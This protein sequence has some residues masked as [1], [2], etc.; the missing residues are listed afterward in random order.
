MAFLSL[1]LLS[2]VGRAQSAPSGA[3]LPVP[4][5]PPTLA[6]QQPGAAS[7]DAAV[8]AAQAF[9]ANPAARAA[10]QR[11]LEAQA[12][13][14]ATAAQRRLQPTF[15]GTA[16][17]SYGQVAQ[18]TSLQSFYTLIGQLTI[19]FPNFGRLGALA[20]QGQAQLRAA[21]VGLD[22]VR[23]DLT[24]RA[25]DAYYGVL[26][27][28]GAEQIAHDNLEQAQRQVADTQKRVDAGDIAPA[29]VLK[30]QVPEAQARA[31]LIRAQ[32]LT[33]V[34]EQSLNSLI[35]R[36]LSAALSLSP[37]QTMPPL[38]LTREQAV[39]RALANSPDVREAQANLDAATA[40]LRVT[41]H[42]RDPELSAQASY[43]NT[44]DITAY[45]SLTTVSVNI[46]LPLDD[47]G[48]A[49]QQKRQAQ[50]QLE[51]ARSALALARQQTQLAA[52]G[53]YLD[54]EADQANVAASQEAARIAQDSLT[55]TRQAFTAGLT[56][57][58]DVLDAQL[59]LA[60][61]RNDA[62]SAVY[63]LAVARA[64]LEQVIAQ[65]TDR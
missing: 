46:T 42:S 20:S 7:L 21:Q 2:D 54:V 34:A 26:R 57:T 14:G 63:D 56:T 16:S 36:E 38:D 61:A 28:R 35:G 55:K 44:G 18:P 39:S 51:Q 53:A 58:R 27:A 4:S 23:L 59:A 22:R 48:V 33:R 3:T 65:R 25:A 37:P 13:L 32:N 43:T 6:A 64:K 50:A 9:A 52:E 41:R 17:G 1:L 40:N 45:S 24:F 11:L 30:A 60:Q 29:E 8:I 62:N 19:P 49:R 5:A 47:G 15:T 10:Q 12:A 31:A